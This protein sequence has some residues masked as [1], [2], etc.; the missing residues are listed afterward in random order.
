MLGIPRRYSHFVFGVLQSGLTSLCASGIVSLPLLHSGHF[1]RNWL[2]SWVV[3]WAAMLPL[4]LFAAPGLRRLSLML[5]REEAS[6][7]S[8]GK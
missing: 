7:A 8:V 6:P 3:S 4:V 1:L 2:L 5:T